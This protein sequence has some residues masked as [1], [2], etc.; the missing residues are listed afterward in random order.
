MG[1]LHPNDRGNANFAARI[2]P[3]VLKLLPLAPETP[4]PVRN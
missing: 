1:G 4:V 3:Q 2:I